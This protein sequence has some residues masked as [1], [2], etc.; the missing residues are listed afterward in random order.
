VFRLLL[1]ALV[2][3]NVEPVPHLAPA[4]LAD[5]QPSS[6]L[7]HL[8]RRVRVLAPDRRW[9]ERFFE[10][11]DAIAHDLRRLA[12]TT[13]APASTPLVRRQVIVRTVVETR[14]V[15]VVPRALIRPP[16]PRFPKPPSV[17][18]AQGRLW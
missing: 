18:P 10:E 3:L 8:A 2:T 1:T 13:W 4:E 11:K 7:E 6:E 14:V 5:P 9:P 16:R 15:V 17:V 12:R